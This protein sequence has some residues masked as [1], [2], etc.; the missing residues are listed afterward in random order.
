[1]VRALHAAGI[2]VI[3]DVVYNHTAEGNHLGPDA[4]ASAAS[5]T[6]PTTGCV[7]DDPRYYVDY[8]GTGNSLNARHPHTL[9]LIMDSLRYWVLE[10]HVD[11]FRFDLAATLARELH[12]VDR[13][14]AFFDLVQQD[15]VVSQVKLIA[16]PWDVGE[17]GYQ[18]GNFPGAVGRMERQVPRHRAR[19]LARR[20]R[21][22]RRVRLPAHRL[23]RPVRGRPAPARRQH[24]LRHRPR[25]VHLDDLVTYNEKHNEANGEDNRDGERPQPVLELRRRGP[26][27]RPGDPGRCG[28]GRC[29]TSWP[30]CSC[31]RAPRCSPHG[32]E[33]GRTQQGNNNAYCQDNELSW[34]DWSLTERNADLLEFSRKVIA[35]RK[36]HPVFRRRR[37]FDGTP[38][39]QRR[40]DP[41]HRLAHA[42]RAGD[43]DGRL[44]QRVRKELAV[45]LNGRAIPEPDARGLPVVDD[46]FLLCFNGHDE[47]LDF[48]VPRGIYGSEWEACL[49]TANPEGNTDLVVRVG[50]KITL[51]ARSIIVFRRPA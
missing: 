44:G 6:P 5:T 31:R 51:E 7:A 49:D 48:V 15:P 25:R 47:D 32:D 4:L 34:M 17:G 39:P 50:D 22:A 2:E 43:D 3:L 45:F 38:D 16:E 37:F 9:Q 24:Q 12:D 42:R 11:G 1:M 40:A 36:H 18:V 23:L 8:T 41:R 33:I 14:S 21:D 20:A 19:L 10:M 27:R 46:S 30:R 29:A 28:P 35:L 26:D 13:L